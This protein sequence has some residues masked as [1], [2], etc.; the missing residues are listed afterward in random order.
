MPYSSL[1]VCQIFY[2]FVIFQ[3]SEINFW[4]M[5]NGYYWGASE[6]GLWAEVQTCRWLQPKP[7]SEGG[8][9]V[10][11]CMYSLYLYSMCWVT[12]KNGLFLGVEK[13]ILL[14]LFCIH[15]SRSPK[16]YMCRN[17]LETR[18]VRHNDVHAQ[19]PLPLKI[20]IW[21]YFYL[22]VWFK[23]NQGVNADLR[24]ISVESDMRNNHDIYLIEAVWEYWTSVAKNLF[25]IHF[26]NSNRSQ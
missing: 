25:T 13:Q 21:I 20:Q 16:V 9:G 17:S 4:A 18:D 15:K 22:L 5:S 3:G 23:N 2:D 12:K 19:W 1:P 7:K 10:C 26:Q 6:F 14:H 24:K 8:G 11:V